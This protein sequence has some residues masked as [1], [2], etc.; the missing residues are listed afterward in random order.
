MYSI[1]ESIQCERNIDGEVKRDLRELDFQ[2]VNNRL[3][4][5]FTLFSL[6]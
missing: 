5:H 1:S 6:R 2:K 4:F 3:E